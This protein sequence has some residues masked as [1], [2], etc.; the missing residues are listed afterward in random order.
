MNRLSS[1]LHID[2]QSEQRPADAEQYVPDHQKGMSVHA[3]KIHGRQSGS[4]RLASPPPACSC[5]LA[6]VGSSRPQEGGHG[7][8]LALQNASAPSL[9]ARRSSA[10]PEFPDPSRDLASE[11]EGHNEREHAHAQKK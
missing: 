9:M 7:L 8:V 2:C 1:S 10:Y 5:A 3:K 6:N 11:E 4:T